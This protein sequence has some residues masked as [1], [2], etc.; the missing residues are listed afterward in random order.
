MGSNFPPTLSEPRPAGRAA[1]SM[2]QRKLLPWMEPCA[3]LKV[4]ISSPPH[5]RQPQPQHKKRKQRRSGRRS[6]RSPAAG[7]PEKAKQ[8]AKWRQLDIQR[9]C[10]SPALRAVS[11]PARTGSRQQRPVDSLAQRSLADGVVPH[12]LSLILDGRQ[13]TVVYFISPHVSHTTKPFAQS[14]A[15]VL[16][17]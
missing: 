5:R 12:N 11:S 13:V 14:L 1:E 8:H 7:K 17:P 4:S 10:K 9:W 2:M 16:T 6:R 15:R 3:N